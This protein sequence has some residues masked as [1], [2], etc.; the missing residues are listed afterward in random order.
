MTKRTTARGQSVDIESIMA[1][2]SDTISVGNM[3]INSR[4]DKLGAGG[5]VVRKA[6]EVTKDQY[7]A[8]TPKVAKVMSTK[9]AVTSTDKN[10][11]K[12]E[13]KSTSTSAVV[14][15]TIDTVIPDDMATDDWVEDKDGNFVKKG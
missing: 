14:E 9:E 11:T 10:T 6:S 5:R 2:Q 3:K 15:K 7:T 4:G 8:D 12:P 13:P 1:Q